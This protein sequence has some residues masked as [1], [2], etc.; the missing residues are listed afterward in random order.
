MIVS[1]TDKMSNEDLGYTLYLNL[2]TDNE[3]WYDHLTGDLYYSKDAGE[4]K[5]G[6]V[7]NYKLEV[8]SNG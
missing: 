7:S 3:Y 1:Y 5:L 6:V 2:I 8:I 4:Y